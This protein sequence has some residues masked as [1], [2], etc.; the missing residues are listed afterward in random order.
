LRVALALV[1]CL[2]VIAALCVPRMAVDGGK[3]G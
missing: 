2:C 3:E 1:V